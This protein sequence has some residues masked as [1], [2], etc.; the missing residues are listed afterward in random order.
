MDW[1]DALQR[2]KDAQADADRGR[3]R[4]DPEAEPAA[5]RGLPDHPQ[6]PWGAPWT[7]LRPHTLRPVAAGPGPRQAPVAHHGLAG[8]RGQA[9]AQG[10]ARGPLR[11]FLTPLRIVSND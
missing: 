7:K 10:R 2:L 4:E 1:R 5:A 9:P 11:A 6:R 3:A 8:V